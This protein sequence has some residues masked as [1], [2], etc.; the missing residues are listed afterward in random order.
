MSKSRKGNPASGNPAKGNPGT[1]KKAA[2]K[3]IVELW[4]Y[5][6][7]IARTGV[8][9]FLI[10]A[11][12]AWMAVYTNVAMDDANMYAAFPSHEIGTSLVWMAKIRMWNYAIGFGLIF[13]GLI[14][15]AHK[16]TPLGRTQGVVIGMVGCFVM[17]LVWIVVF[18]FASQYGW[19][20]PV[21]DQL[22]QLPNLG[23]GV[24][25]MAVGFVFSTK[26]E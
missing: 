20:I 25:F 5:P 11:G 9:L 19:P 14:V 18:Y 13:L 16:L 23:V 22:D 12:I 8:A 26:W 10:L 7:S 24:G 6:T 2:P 21:M 1:D 4:G 3:G 15:S 17:G